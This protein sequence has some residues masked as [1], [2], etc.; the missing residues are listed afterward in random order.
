M[1]N[2]HATTQNTQLCEPNWS[3]DMEKQT[4]CTLPLPHMMNVDESSSSSSPSS[5]RFEDLNSDVARKLRKF[6]V[7]NDGELDMT[8]A[9]QALITLQKQSDNYKKTIWLL[10]PLLLAL[11][12]SVFGTTI[13]AIRLTQE[14]KVTNG[15]MITTMDGSIA[16]VIST[17]FNMSS[18]YVQQLVFT[19]DIV[20]LSDISVKPGYS[21]K[22]TGVA[23]NLFVNPHEA[24][25]STQFFTLTMFSNSTTIL[26][27]HVGYES[28]PMVSAYQMP[29][30]SFT[31]MSTAFSTAGKPSAAP[32]T[33]PPSG[34]IKPK[35]CTQGC[36]GTESGGRRS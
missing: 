30:V 12:G 17:S 13:L 6:D 21:A 3:K 35:Q 23:Q 8:E 15:N 11:V 31:F 34:T 19:P 33:P 16:E 24:Y 2:L 26:T 9:V 10:I 28:H 27:P 36:P 20:A 14:L 18:E 7:S 32:V 22:V 4:K 29:T 1:S 25:I 5:I